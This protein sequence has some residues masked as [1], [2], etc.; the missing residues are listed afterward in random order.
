MIFREKID[1]TDMQKWFAMEISKI[2]VTKG[3]QANYSVRNILTYLGLRI[4]YWWFCYTALV[5]TN[6]INVSVNS[7]TIALKDARKILSSYNLLIGYALLSTV[8][9]VHEHHDILKCFWRN[10]V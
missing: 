1:I 6:L 5:L 9:P 8:P 4:Y 2:V 10:N 3:F 7:E